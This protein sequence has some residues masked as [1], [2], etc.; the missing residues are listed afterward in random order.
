MTETESI[1]S[2]VRTLLLEAGN[3]SRDVDNYLDEVDELRKTVEEHLNKWN[4]FQSTLQY[5]KVVKVIDNLRYCLLLTHTLKFP[6]KFLYKGFFTHYFSIDLERE[7]MNKDDEKC[8]TVFANLC[9]ISRNLINS[10]ANNLRHYLKETLIHWHNILKQKFAR[11]IIIS[12]S[13]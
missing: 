3:V 5:F 2:N 1:I 10:K 6:I 13:K 7:I 8:A 11:F 9:E 4:T 12:I